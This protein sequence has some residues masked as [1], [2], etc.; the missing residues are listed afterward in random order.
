MLLHAVPPDA[1]VAEAVH[2]ISVPT[3]SGMRQYIHDVPQP[4]IAL[5]VD[6]N[7]MPRDTTDRPRRSIISI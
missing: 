6:G 5:R 7:I 1:V 3:Y 2:D 4:L